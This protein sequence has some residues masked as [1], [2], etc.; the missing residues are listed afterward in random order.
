MT[1]LFNQYA[2]ADDKR[3]AKAFK[4]LYSAID[5]F[6]KLTPAQKQRLLHE[7]FVTKWLENIEKGKV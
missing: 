1:D 6:N 5:S 4:E 2:S 3:Y 7:V